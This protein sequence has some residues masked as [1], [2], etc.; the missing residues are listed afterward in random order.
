MIRND[1]NGFAAWLYRKERLVAK[2]NAGT[3]SI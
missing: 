3:T 2:A 1:K